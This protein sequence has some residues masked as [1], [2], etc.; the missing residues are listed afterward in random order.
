[1]S[2]PDRFAI[3]LDALA[4][5]G[6]VS[7]VTGGI[8]LVDRQ[9]RRI[10]TRH[11]PAWQPRLEWELLFT[12]AVGAGAHVMFPRVVGGTPVVF[13]EQHVYAEDYGLWWRLSRAGKVV[14]V[15][16]VLYRYRR[17]DA[18]ISSRQRA[19]QEGCVSAI[20][21]AV[22]S[23]YV[24]LPPATADELSRFWTCDGG[25]LPRGRFPAIASGLADLRASF[26]AYVD[27]RFGPSDRWAL[28]VEIDDALSGRL[29]Y[30]LHRSMRFLDWSTSREL[31]KTALSRRRT[32]TVCQ[33]ALAW[34]TTA[35]PRRLRYARNQS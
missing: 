32:L 19:M 31:L 15:P 4:G 21:S 20:R 16:G 10:E 30:W 5:A 18:S 33:E 23:T 24:R 26:L 34:T 9:G 29:G 8:E 35:V 25:R 28:E 11:P 2:V 13:P 17:H 12:N 22:Q 1:V 7:L 6:N 14:C 27:S 3:Q